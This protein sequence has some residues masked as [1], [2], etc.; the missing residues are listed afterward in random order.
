[1]GVV[2][3]PAAFTGTRTVSRSAPLAGAEACP[4]EAVLSP[5]S[6]HARPNGSDRRLVAVVIALALVTWIFAL[7]GAA[8]AIR[9]LLALCFAT[10]AGRGRRVGVPAIAIPAIGSTPKIS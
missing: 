6:R 9:A 1:M 3:R 8:F 7:A 10:L 5:R 4:A 2:I